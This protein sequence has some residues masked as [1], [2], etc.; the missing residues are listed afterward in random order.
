MFRV[1]TL[2][3]IAFVAAFTMVG[4]PAISAAAPGSVADVIALNWV[5][6]G[7]Q[8]A[9]FTEDGKVKTEQRLRMSMDSDAT[10][11]GSLSVTFTLDGSPYRATFD[12]SGRYLAQGGKLSFRATGPT[13]SDPLPHEL[14]WCGASGTLEIFND[15]E[16]EGHFVL[17]GTLDLSCGGTIDVEFT[18]R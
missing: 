13:R 4:A 11:H 17:K 8:S 6:Y 14:H 10:L 2:M 5:G 7:I 3:P 18:D 15:T 12:V 16:R 1:P 9:D